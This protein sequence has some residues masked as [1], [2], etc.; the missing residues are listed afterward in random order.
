[1]SNSFKRMLAFLL[2]SA[3]CWSLALTIVSIHWWHFFNSSCNSYKLLHLEY[4][5]QFYQLKYSFHQSQ[6]TTQKVNSYL[7]GNGGN[8][9]H[10]LNV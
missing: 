1:M 10:A 2:A 6:M 7:V 9:S 3:A 5:P 4:I 8:V